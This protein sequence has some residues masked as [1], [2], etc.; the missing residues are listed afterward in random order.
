MSE[1]EA[2]IEGQ[3]SFRKRILDLLVLMPVHDLTAGQWEGYLHK[4]VLT[5]VRED[6][7]DLIL[8]TP[9]IMDPPATDKMS[10]GGM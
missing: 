5:I 4:P 7:R 6:L 3:R 10:V 9:F 2:F 8:T 1:R